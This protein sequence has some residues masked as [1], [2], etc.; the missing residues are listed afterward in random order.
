LPVLRVIGALLS[1]LVALCGVAA[2]EEDS[3]PSQ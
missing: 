3:P 2:E 1:D